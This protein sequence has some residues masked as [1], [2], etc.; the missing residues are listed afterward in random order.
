M[1]TIETILGL[2]CCLVAIAL[3]LVAR[4]ASLADRDMRQPEVK[5]VY[6]GNWMDSE[7]LEQYNA[8]MNEFMEQWR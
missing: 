3:W 7:T 8:E 5:Q 1:R 6:R 4:M 2:W